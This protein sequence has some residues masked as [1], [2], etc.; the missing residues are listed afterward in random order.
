MDPTAPPSTRRSD[1][2]YGFASPCAPDAPASPARRHLGSGAIHLVYK[3]TKIDTGE[4]YVGVHSTEN[5]NDGYLGS[6]TWVRRAVRKHGR[7]AFLNEIVQVCAT[8]AEAFRIEAELVTQVVGD[9]LCMNLAPGGISPPSRIGAKHSDESRKRMSKAHR[10]QTL[11]ET[12]RQKLS[13]A[14]QGKVFSPEHRSKIGQ[15]SVVMRPPSQAPHVVALSTQSRHEKEFL[16]ACESVGQNA[17]AEGRLE[18][19]YESGDGYTQSS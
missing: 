12:H 5:L 11:D 9:C 6:G 8:R 2:I 14:A 18:V 10:G 1:L 16:K 4:Y 17:A 3:T 15:A 7:T 13:V 19:S